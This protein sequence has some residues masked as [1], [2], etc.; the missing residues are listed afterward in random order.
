MKLSTQ[1]RTVSNA[2]DQRQPPPWN[3]RRDCP[4]LLTAKQRTSCKGIST[5]VVDTLPTSDASGP[6]TGSRHP[7]QANWKP[8]T[9][10]RQNHPTSSAIWWPCL[11]LPSGHRGASKAASQQGVFRAQAMCDFCHQFFRSH[12]KRRLSQA[13][14]SEDRDSS[15]PAPLWEFPFSLLLSSSSS[16]CLPFFLLSTCTRALSTG[17]QQTKKHLSSPYPCLTGGLGRR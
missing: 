13:P 1:I 5:K 4:P 9:F 8:L 10:L 11:G 17:L 3:K 6:N 14:T 2:L 7:A 12:L 15:P 16:A